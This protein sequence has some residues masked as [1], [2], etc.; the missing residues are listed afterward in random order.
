[1]V[2]VLLIGFEFANQIWLE[3]SDTKS[4][5]LF[6]SN[7]TIILTEVEIEWECL[8]K[9][10]NGRKIGSGRIRICFFS[11]EGLYINRNPDPQPFRSIWLT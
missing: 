9:Y 5:K 11:S 1:M 7:F 10:K 6:Y 8:K 2:L 3:D 4:V